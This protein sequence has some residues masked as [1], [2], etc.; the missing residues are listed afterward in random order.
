LVKDIEGSL[1]KKE[2]LITDIIEKFPSTREVFAKHGVCSGG[3]I[4]RETLE[5]F[6]RA[7]QVN[8]DE[9]L[10]ELNKASHNS[11]STKPETTAPRESIG[12]VLWRRF[13]KFGIVFGSIGWA[14]GAVNLAYIAFKRSY[15]ELPIPVILSHAHIQ[16]FGWVGLFVMGFAYQ[17][18]P[19]FKFV[20]L[21]NP[22]LA[23]LSLWIIV[24][25]ISLTVLS[26]ALLPSNTFFILGAFGSIG[27]LIAIVI[28]FVVV[29]KT[30]NRAV[31]KRQFWEKYVFAA[32]VFFL[33]QALLNPVLFYLVG[34]ASL[35]SNMPL[36]IERVAGFVAP[37]QDIQLFGF[38]VMMVF[39]V[40]QRFVPF[41]FNTKKPSR[42]LG[43]FLFYMFL[44]SLLLS[45]SMHLI[46]RIYKL[47][48]LRPFILVPYLGF[49]IS[50]IGVI[51]NIGI[52]GRA[53]DTSRSL[54]FIRAA[55]IWLIV[56]MILLLFLPLYSHFVHGMF[57]H[58]YFGA[59]RH[60]LTVGFISL[61][62]MG[63][64][65]RVTPIMSGVEPKNSLMIPFILINI[66]NAMRVISQILSDFE[67]VISI[68]ALNPFFVGASGF[69]QVI[70][71]SLWA[72]DTWSTANEGIRHQKKMVLLKEPPK[73]IEKW[74]KVGEILDYYPQI[75]EVF[76]KFGFKDITNPIL[77]KTVGKTIPLEMACRMH[78]VNIDE[79]LT[80]LN[81]YITKH[82]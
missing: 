24:F 18:F 47:E 2:M 53:K 5:F 8:L 79:F 14:F 81:S 32:L 37:Y 21:W 35:K 23:N 38:I 33:I 13:F 55:Y 45:V 16:I 41:V 72:Y 25:S 70:G 75:E 49:F 58:N 52:L 44:F 60:A 56:S 69:I 64:A 59:Y 43:D 66:G 61:M 3:I 1:I 39:G 74:M 31:E 30:M 46:I 57:S 73:R 36:L 26:W 76:L 68:L 48:L 20:S 62:I 28:F 63:V 78:L 51:L 80:E 71:F 82:L 29:L 6:S 9:I 40:S 19:R 17:A 50:S 15:F 27:E 10:V 12:E 65:S 77:R 22:S 42:R 11:S 67:G 54:K 7:H 34:D 4:P